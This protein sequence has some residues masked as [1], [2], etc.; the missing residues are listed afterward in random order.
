MQTAIRKFP[1][2]AELN[3]RKEVIGWVGEEDARRLIKEGKASLTGPW[4]RRALRITVQTGEKIRFASSEIR[5]TRYSHNHE[6]R[7]NPENVWTLLRLARWTQSVFLAQLLEQCA[8]TA[9]CRDCG[10]RFHATPQAAEEHD[11]TYHRRRKK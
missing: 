3:G 1:L 4:R 10:R 2:V 7:E 8:V 5:H 11:R 9:V 6:T